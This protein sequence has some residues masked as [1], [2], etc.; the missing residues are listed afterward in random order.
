[1]ELMNNAAI[2]FS[3]KGSGYRCRREWEVLLSGSAL[4][5]DSANKRD[6]VVIPDFIEDLHF[7][8]LNH[9]DTDLPRM[10]TERRDHLQQLSDDGHALARRCFVDNALSL[11]ERYLRVY[12]LDPAVAIQG[13]ADLERREKELN[14]EL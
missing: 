7:F 2:C 3:P 13:Y 1:L 10:L 9:V 5:L 6:E 11:N 8:Y 4:W 12:L 14:L